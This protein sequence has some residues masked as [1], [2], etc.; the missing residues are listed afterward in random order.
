MMDKV[1]VIAYCFPEFHREDMK[2]EMRFAMFL[3]KSL[4]YAKYKAID[5]LRSPAVS[6]STNGKTEHVSVEH[7]MDNDFDFPYT[8]DFD[9][10]DTDIKRIMSK[11]STSIKRTINDWFWKGLIAKQEMRLYG[12]KKYQ[13]YR[14]RKE[15][16]QFIREELG[17][18]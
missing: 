11:C 6:N 3:G 7:R 10:V 15:A 4:L 14:R 8:M 16:M 18:N 13:V 17:I 9:M 2:Q 5:Y 12:E 1:E